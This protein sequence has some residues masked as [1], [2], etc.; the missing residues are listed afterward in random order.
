MREGLFL[1]SGGEKVDCRLGRM[2]A[3]TRIPHS[4]EQE[5]GKRCWLRDTVRPC[6]FWVI[7]GLGIP[8][9]GMGPCG[10]NQRAGACPSAG[11]R[12]S[13]SS[14]CSPSSSSFCLPLSHL[15]HQLQCV[16][17]HVQAKPL[18]L[19][20]SLCLLIL[21]FPLFFP[22]LALL[23]FLYHQ[24]LLLPLHAALMSHNRPQ[25]TPL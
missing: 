8:S 3:E 5:K 9:A 24:T 2:A 12:N 10:R 19:R 15:L 1:A 25:C 18:P 11:A 22:L 13:S 20:N 16:F 6:V 14:S 4:P 21:S 17:Q 23:F 7:T